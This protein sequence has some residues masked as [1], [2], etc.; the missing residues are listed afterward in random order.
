MTNEDIIREARKRIGEAYSADME[1]R[2]HALDDLRMIR[3]DQWPDSERQARE[4]EGK[5]CL[6]FNGLAQ[7]VRQVTGQIRGMNPAIRVVPGDNEASDDVAE[8][9][10]GLIRQIENRCG[11]DSIYE[12]AAESSAA[13]G[14]GH[15]R[16]R[17]D[18]CDGD[19]FD[20]EI[21]IERIHNPF[22]VFWD[23]LA[24]MPTREDARYCFIV[25]EV[26]REDFKAEYPDADMSILTSD[27]SPESGIV[28]STPDTV[29]VAEYF[30]IEYATHKI[31]MLPDGTIVRDPRPPEMFVK[32]RDVRTPVVKWAKITG[33]DV[34]DG[35]L[36]VPSRYIPVVSVTGE[37][38]HIGESTHRSSVVRYAKDAQQLYNFSRSTGA[39]VMALQPRAP[40]LVTA[41]QVS[42]L[43]EFW[44]EAN[45]SNRPYLPYNP[46]GA[47]PPPMRVPPPVPSS[48]VMSEIQLS[49]EDMKRTTGIY[50]AS[51]GARSNETSGIAI[52]RRQQE[53]QNGTSIYADNMVKG[54]THTGRILVDMIPRVYDTQRVI[55]ILGED[56]QEKQVVINAML[57]G[58]G[59]IVPVN[60]MTVGRYD[61]RISVGPSFNTRRAEAADGMMEFLR[62]VPQAA[63]LAADL[64]AGMQDWPESDRIAERLRKT[65]PQGIAEEDDDMTPE[66]AQQMQAMRQ[67]QAA[68]KQQADQMAQAAMEADVRKKIAEAAEAEADAKKAMAEAE[69][70]RLKLAQMTGQIDA[71]IS[72]ASQQGFAAGAAS[73][74]ALGGYGPTGL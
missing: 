38:W 24:K 8:I 58:S 9:Y 14:I 3:G 27:H 63:P 69:E 68:Q 57:Q 65:L 46:D 19:T 21:L 70:A 15:W 44:A 54:V 59:G 61:V 47:A 74:P 31:G 39:E 42:G 71:A 16:L 36:D 34:L 52:T 51:L 22:S 11:A 73:A 25:E 4:L 45:Q 40:Y 17:A 50:D 53:A 26:D 23:P 28:W 29:T 5:P 18:Y 7:F 33:G 37:E 64:I 12:Q 35:P 55:R 60:D 62:V 43:E 48:A 13:C 1:N 10:A 49:A 32:T 6:T 56:D 41:K 66:K 20:Q 72:Q 67:Q 30:W 2:D